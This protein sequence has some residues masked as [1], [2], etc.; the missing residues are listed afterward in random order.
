M[1]DGIDGLEPLFA[2]VLVKRSDYS[3]MVKAAER[4]AQDPAQLPILL[5]IISRI[6]ADCEW[7]LGDDA[8]LNAIRGPQN[9]SRDVVIVGDERGYYRVIWPY[10]PLTDGRPRRTLWRSD[11]NAREVV[12]V[13]QS[14]ITHEAVKRLVKFGLLS[15]GFN[16]LT[17]TNISQESRLATLNFWGV[18]HRSHFWNC[19]PARTWSSVIP[20][21]RNLEGAWLVS[22]TGEP[23]A[24]APF[25]DDA[26]FLANCVNMAMRLESDIAWR[27]GGLPDLATRIEQQG[28]LGLVM[29]LKSS[30]TALEFGEPDPPKGL[31]AQG[32]KLVLDF[33]QYMIDL[34]KF[35]PGRRWKL[36]DIP[37]RP[38]YISPI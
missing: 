11:D 4:A 31:V 24:W 15:D 25:P 35:A 27:G 29:L 22:G 28:I 13:D 5:E 6:E 17:L 33:H 1:D 23:V 19:S 37:P 36:F 20:S 38:K 10:E 12:V 32:I 34:R 9:D 16:G 21:E 7:G 14:P 26:K 30:I 8:T 18:A 2:P 3:D